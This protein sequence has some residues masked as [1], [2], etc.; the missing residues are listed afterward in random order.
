MLLWLRWAL[1]SVEE[2]IPGH[3]TVQ[4]IQDAL[5]DVPDGL[6]EIYVQEMTRIEKYDV[7][8]ALRVFQW[9]CLSTEPMSLTDLRTAVCLAELS[10]T[11]EIGVQMT[12]YWRSEF[13][14]LVWAS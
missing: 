12:S 8:F 13:T 3:E 7:D 5:D 2:L 4:Y 10:T 11:P 1:K 6:T 14:E 9:I